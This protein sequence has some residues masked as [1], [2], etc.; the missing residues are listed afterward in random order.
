MQLVLD[1]GLE[2]QNWPSK[3]AFPLLR[4]IIELKSLFLLVS[5]I[6]LISQS[7]TGG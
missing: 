1:V 3:I 4:D 2:L 5:K 6:N 7:V